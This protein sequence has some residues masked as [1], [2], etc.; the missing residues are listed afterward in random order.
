MPLFFLFFFCPT[1]T[2]THT[3]CLLCNINPNILPKMVCWLAVVIIDTMGGKTMVENACVLITLH[4]HFIYIMFS[5]SYT[6]SDKRMFS[7]Y[8]SSGCLENWVLVGCWFNVIPTNRRGLEKIRW[9]ARMGS[10]SAARVHQA[11]MNL[12]WCGCENLSCVLA[13]ISQSLTLAIKLLSL[14]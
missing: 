14:I 1:K 8:F 10:W 12:M 5:G 9:I 6:Q 11:L 7:L 4:T 3:A 13:T 2:H